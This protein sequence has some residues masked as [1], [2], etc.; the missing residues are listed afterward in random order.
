MPANYNYEYM[1]LLDKLI[2]AYPD[3]IEKRYPVAFRMGDYSLKV[4]VQK[5]LYMQFGF[6][7]HLRG[8]FNLR[9]A[10]GWFSD[11]IER[12]FR[13]Q[14]FDRY[15]F[16]G[17]ETDR[18]IEENPDYLDYL[19]TNLK[20]FKNKIVYYALHE[21]FLKFALPVLSAIPEEVV[22]LC[23]RPLP[24]E[25]ECNENIPVIE[26]S[27]LKL[28]T[29]SNPFLQEKFPWM[30]FMFNS[31]SLLWKVLQPRAVIVIEG[32]HPQFEVLALLGQRDHVPV[33][34]LQQGWPGLLHTGFRNMQYSHFISWGRRFSEMLG[35]LNP[36]PRFK[37]AGYP[38]KVEEGTKRDAISF[39]LQAPLQIS[40]LNDYNEL[41][42]FSIYCAQQFPRLQILVREHPEFRLPGHYKEK[43]ECY[44]NIRLTPPSVCPISIVY[45]QSI[46][47][48]SIFSSAIIESLA[49]GVIP[50]IFNPT[51]M[52]HYYPDLGSEGLGIEV[53]SLYEAK[54]EICKLMNDALLIK[55]YQ[56]AIS[57]RRPEF[58]T[59]TGEEAVKN[60]VCAIK[61]C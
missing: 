14:I 40:S 6:N 10:E 20:P 12:Y 57:G 48:V 23:E 18:Q 1:V 45:G 49:H 19:E 37:E 16:Q 53:K 17:S 36:L 39:F 25:F 11:D 47:S 7:D 35:V 55:K 44:E 32:N 33:I 30:F 24:D 43:A 29:Y 27:F 31:L 5:H 58:F 4:P 60:I 46:V 21:R 26:F 9:C 61:S 38:F 15:S 22:V 50:F 3:E 42:E 28:C 2:A 54:K 56:E 52:P 41:L 34:C 51:S 8:E 59:A 13:Q